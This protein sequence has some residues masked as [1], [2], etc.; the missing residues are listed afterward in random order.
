MQAD[1]VARSKITTGLKVALAKLERKLCA[2]HRQVQQA[3]T[4]Q[5]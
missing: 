5:V 4:D 3:D 1:A 2:L